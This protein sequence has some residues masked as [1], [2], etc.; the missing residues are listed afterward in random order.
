M[1]KRIA[2]FFARAASIIL[3]GSV[4]TIL[5]G[6]LIAIWG[7]NSLGSKITATGFVVAAVSILIG[8]ATVGVPPAGTEG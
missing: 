7:Q 8:F 6:I 5:V 4:L 1:S 3:I 2:L